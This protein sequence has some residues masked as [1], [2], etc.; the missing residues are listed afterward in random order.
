MDSNELSLVEKISFLPG[1]GIN[2]SDTFKKR[3]IMLLPPASR[4][5]TTS[6]A[7]SIMRTFTFSEDKKAMNIS[8]FWKSF[9]SYA[10]YE[11]RLFLAIIA[12]RN[13]VLPVPGGPE[14]NNNGALEPRY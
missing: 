8:S 9:G 11:C 1:K 13:V 10:T 7:S 2:P 14:R 12:R 4:G 5:F 3:D 6:S